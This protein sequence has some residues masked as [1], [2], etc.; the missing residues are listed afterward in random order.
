VV[1]VDHHPETADPIAAE[2][3]ITAPVAA[4]C[5]VLVEEFRR[6]DIA[7]DQQT[8]TLMLLGIYEDTGGLT[9]A[10]TTPA[11]IEAAAWLVQRG[12]RLDWVR[13]YVLRPLEPEQ[14]LLLNQLVEGAVEHQVG[15]VRVVITVARP[16][17]RVEEAAYVI[18]RY[19]EIFDVPIVL[20]LLESRRSWW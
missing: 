19:A 12:G 4:T 5:T 16:S 8:A 10:D 6:R 3:V 7:P 2:E 17:E 11:D 15:G 20:A 1:V 13:R 18:H 14:L 9:Y